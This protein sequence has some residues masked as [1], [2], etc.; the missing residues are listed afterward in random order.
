MMTSDH[1]SHNVGR[2]HQWLGLAVD[3]AKIRLR[4][5]TRRLLW[6]LTPGEREHRVLRSELRRLERDPKFAVELRIELAEGWL[7]VRFDRGLAE[8]VSG[9]AGGGDRP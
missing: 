3:A 7:R 1:Q 5:R 9:R 2:V 4:S 8:L 6:S